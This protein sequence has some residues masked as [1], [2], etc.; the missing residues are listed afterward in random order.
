MCERTRAERNEEFRIEKWC[1]AV[2]RCQRVLRPGAI[3]IGIVVLLYGAEQI[4][5]GASF[6]SKHAWSA[7]QPA[8]WLFVVTSILVLSGYFLVTRA[9]ARELKNGEQN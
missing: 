8:G 3:T 6:P 9:Y 4:A 1:Q 2:E 7:G 5:K